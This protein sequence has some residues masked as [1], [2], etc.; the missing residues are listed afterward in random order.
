MERGFV[1]E[2][3]MNVLADIY[4]RMGRERDAARHVALGRRIEQGGT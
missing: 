3:P 2:I 1:D 4:T